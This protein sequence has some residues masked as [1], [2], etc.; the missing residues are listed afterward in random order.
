M[1]KLILAA[2]LAL[3]LAGCWNPFIIIDTKAYRLCIDKHL[4]YP[5]FVMIKV[6][7]GNVDN[8][9]PSIGGLIRYYNIKRDFYLYEKAKDND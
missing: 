6:A 8:A 2:T 9:N 3:A 1:I 4:D 5:K 7:C